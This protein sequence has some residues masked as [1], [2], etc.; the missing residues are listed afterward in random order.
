MQNM[1]NFNAKAV[2]EKLI[3]WIRGYFKESASPD[4]KAIIG[5][6]GGKDSSVVA[7]LCAAALGKDRVL[8]VL[9]PQGIQEDIN[10]SYA[11][12]KTLD[13][14]YLEVNIKNAVDETYA[15]MPIKDLNSITTFNT[16][17]RIRMTVLYAVSG[18]VGGRVSNNCNLSEDFVGYATKFGD[19]AGD[20]SPLAELTATEVKAIGREL[21]LGAMFTDKPPAD[22]L[23][24]KTDED[25]LGFSY[26]VLDAYIRDGVCDDPEILNKITEMNKAGQHKL[27]PIPAFEYSR[28]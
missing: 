4:T 17:A 20:F 15:A 27:N 28:D 24:G 21:G 9:M 2:T 13:I 3:D 25:N 26:D 7:A 8:G 19:G 1:N 5:V 18:T 12:C 11:L 10:V 6:S 14:E 16:P 22:G 23:C